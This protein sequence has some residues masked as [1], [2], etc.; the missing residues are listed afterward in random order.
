M[1]LDTIFKAR[2][3]TG[4]REATNSSATMSSNHTRNVNTLIKNILITTNNNETSMLSITT[5]QE[6]T[7]R[8]ATK[9]V[10]RI[11]NLRP[12]RKSI[13]PKA[14]TKKCTYQKIVQISTRLKATR[15][16]LMNNIMGHTKSR[17]LI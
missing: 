15:I 2:I 1:I 13:V 5:N 6:I 11:N 9:E 10:L 12:N 17:K 8:G 7:A 3:V 16:Q 14:L 4:Q